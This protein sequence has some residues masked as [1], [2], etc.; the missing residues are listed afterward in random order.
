MSKAR[1]LSTKE[2]V[3]LLDKSVQ[4][5][6]YDSLLRYKSKGVLIFSNVDLSSSLIGHQFAIGWGPENSMTEVPADGKCQVRPP[7]GH[8]W[9]YYLDAYSDDLQEGVHAGGK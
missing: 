7:Q 9:Q 3:E 5:Q 1:H 4:Q 2:C 6:V 8:H